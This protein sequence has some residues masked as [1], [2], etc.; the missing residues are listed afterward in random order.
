MGKPLESIE[1]L[2]ISHFHGDHCF[3]LPFIFL[4]HYFMTKR[5]NPLTI[6]GPKGVKKLAL[7]LIDL[8]FPDTRSVMP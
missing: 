6:I 7:T 1:Y 5:E 4:D 2:F 3:G 8:A